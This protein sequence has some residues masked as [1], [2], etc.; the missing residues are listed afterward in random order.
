VKKQAADLMLQDLISLLTPMQGAIVAYSGGVDSTFLLKALKLSGIKT[1]AITADSD[2]IPYHEVLFAKKIAK[3]LGIPHHIIQTDILS[4]K[5][6]AQNSPE[7]CYVC[8]EMLFQTLSGI[9]ASGGY[10]VILDGSTINDTDDYRPGRKAAKKYS[11]RSPLTEA[12]LSKDTIRKLSRKLGLPTWNKPSSSCLA[13]RIPYGRILTKD[14]LERIEKSEDFLRSLGFHQI[15][16]RE[17]DCIARIEVG[18]SEIAAM[19]STKKREIISK[20]LKSF[21][22]TYISLDI[23]GYESGSLNRVLHGKSTKWTAPGI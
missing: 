12:G 2:I 10:Q 13:T 5:E 11:V 1:L 17:H 7:R 23:D 22:Y 15:R 21:G 16:V 3:E 18:K 20:T 4:V 14:L 9:A 19:L 6:F 8:K